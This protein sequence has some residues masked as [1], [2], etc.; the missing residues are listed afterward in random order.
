M[1]NKKIKSLKTSVLCCDNQLM[2]YLRVKTFLMINIASIYE[3][4]GKRLR[5]IVN[6]YS[7]WSIS[8]SKLQMHLSDVHSVWEYLENKMTEKEED[9]Q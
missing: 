3:I 1:L 4:E 8:D 2:L 5:L 7:S 9:Q 6:I